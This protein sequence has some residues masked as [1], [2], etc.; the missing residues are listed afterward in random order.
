[1]KDTKINDPS[2]P[3]QRQISTSSILDSG[4]GGL[5][6]YT[7]EIYAMIDIFMNQVM[8]VWEAATPLEFVSAER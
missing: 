8:E 6:L 2:I 1:V 7:K 3:E 4:G 5:V